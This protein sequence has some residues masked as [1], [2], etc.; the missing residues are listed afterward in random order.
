MVRHHLID[1]VNTDLQ[2][3]KQYDPSNNYY[4]HGTITDSRTKNYF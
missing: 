3:K 2:R 1:L 4:E